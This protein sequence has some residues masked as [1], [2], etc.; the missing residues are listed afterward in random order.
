MSDE[1]VIEKVLTYID[2]HIEEELSLDTIAA[3][4]N[5]SKF[6]MARI[7]AKR[8][9]YTIYKYIQ[10]RRLTQA[11]QKLVETNKPIVEIAYEAQYSSQQAFTQAFSRVYQCSPQVY[12]K[13]GIFYPV[14]MQIVLCMSQRLCKRNYHMGGRM[15][16]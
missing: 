13:N 6:Y 14:Q 3:V 4:F 12:R 1:N 9:G 15:A 8:T 16:A 2:D 5:Y 7:F 11:A 10:G